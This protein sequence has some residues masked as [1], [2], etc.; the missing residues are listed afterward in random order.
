MFKSLT[1][2]LTCSNNILTYITQSETVSWPLE[3]ILFGSK[4]STDYDVIVNTPSNIIILH[5]HQLLLICDKINNILAQQNIFSFNK[6]INTCLGYWQ[7]GKL[8]WSQKG[9]I[10][11]T[12]NAIINTFKHHHQLFELCPLTNLMIREKKDIQLKIMAALRMIT[13][14]FTSATTDYNDTFDILNMIVNVKEVSLLIGPNRDRF[15]ITLI[16][17]YDLKS[18]TYNKIINSLNNT[19]I[20]VENIDSEMKKLISIR[21]KMV[22]LRKEFKINIYKQLYEESEKSINIIKWNVKN[23]K[24][25]LDEDLI[26]IF[27]DEIN[28]CTLTL[29]GITRAV[30]NAKYVCFQSDFLKFIDFT[31]IDLHNAVEDKLKKIAFQIGQTYGLLSGTELYEKETIAETYP[32]LSNVLFR[33]KL[34]NDDLKRLTDMKNKFV[35]SIYSFIERT[36]IE[37]N[38]K[39]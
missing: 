14:V 28:G 13:G 38:M 31:K 34:T 19:D 32:V 26:K 16:K 33:K 23:N 3:Y 10:A 25:N 37:L 1:M 9:T 18:T 30:L 15:M 8:L 36:F 20:D 24:K 39:N 29:R 12:N 4:S 17:V 21:K 27:N 6:S 22:N 11:E 2:D 5:P 7:N 35:D